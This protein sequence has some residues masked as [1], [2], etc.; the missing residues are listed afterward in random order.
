M[1]D[2]QLL[3]E[4]LKLAQGDIELLVTH[5]NLSHCLRQGYQAPLEPVFVQSISANSKKHRLHFRDVES[6]L[7][8]Y[9]LVGFRL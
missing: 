7:S 4:S 5:K 6:G 3:G 8:V 1:T 2:H 9:Q